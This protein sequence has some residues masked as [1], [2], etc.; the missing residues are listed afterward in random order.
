MTKAPSLMHLLVGFCGVLAL[1]NIAE[2]AYLE[3]GIEQSR[4]IVEQPV[5]SN[6]SL[7]QIGAHEFVLPP[8]EAYSEIVERPVMIEGR[9]P[10]PEEA[11]QPILAAPVSRGDMKIKLMGIVKTPNGMIALLTDSKGAYQRVQIDSA[12]DGWE[13]DEMHEDRIVLS[14]GAE[15]EEVKLRKPKPKN[16]LPNARGQSQPQ[17]QSK[18]AVPLKQVSPPK[19]PGKLKRPVIPKQGVSQ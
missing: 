11:E 15:R 16:P 9:H 17:S 19:Q 6:V 4:K 14:Q 2:W 7:G 1:V 5:D 18:P 10:V 12:I 13:V 8:K 3:Y